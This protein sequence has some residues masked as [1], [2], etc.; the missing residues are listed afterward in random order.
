MERM[1]WFLL[2]NINWRVY[3]IFLIFEILILLNMLFQTVPVITGVKYLI[4]NI[5]LFVFANWST[6]RFN[7]IN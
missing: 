7:V 4:I 1:Y 6:K 3:W 2:R 5:L